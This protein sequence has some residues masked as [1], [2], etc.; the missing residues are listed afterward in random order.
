M[1]EYICLVPTDGYSKGQIVKMTEEE[2]RNQNAGEKN[3]RFAP[4]DGAETPETTE[5]E[6]ATPE[7]DTTPETTEENPT[8]ETTE[9]E[10]KTEENPE[11]TV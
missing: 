3:P 6:T 8:P 1:N 5:E 11:A 9:E 10:P 7:A 2:F 4:I